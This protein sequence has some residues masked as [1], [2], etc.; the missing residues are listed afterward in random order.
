NEIGASL[1]DESDSSIDIDKDKEANWNSDQ[2]PNKNTPKF[3]KQNYSAIPQ[4]QNN[5]TIT[6]DSPADQLQIQRFSKGNST[7]QSKTGA[8]TPRQKVKRRPRGESV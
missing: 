3:A 2:Q 8:K 6:L 4:S 1:A 7:G 5:T